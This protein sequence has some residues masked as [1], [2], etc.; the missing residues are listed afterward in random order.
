M[1][2][3]SYKQY[4]F[5]KVDPDGRKVLA[6]SINPENPA[7][8][9]APSATMGRPSIRGSGT[10]SGPLRILWRGCGRRLLRKSQTSWSS[11]AWGTS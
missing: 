4:E 5:I 8:S 10:T 1:N 3:F 11:S 7:S 2:Y 9:T 6:V